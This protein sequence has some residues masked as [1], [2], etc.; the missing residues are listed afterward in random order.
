MPIEPPAVSKGRRIGYEKATTNNVLY[1]IS[2]LFLNIFTLAPMNFYIRK[3]KVGIWGNICTLH[4]KAWL[5]TTYTLYAFPN[6][7]KMQKQ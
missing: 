5:T 1:P 7:Y 4:N 3:V 6:Y 2:M